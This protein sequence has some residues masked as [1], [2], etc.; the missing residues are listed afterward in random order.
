MGHLRPALHDL[1]RLP[2]V[3]YR[4]VISDVVEGKRIVV[5]QE[6]DGT[7]WDARLDAEELRHKHA[8]V[9]IYRYTNGET[10]RIWTTEPDDSPF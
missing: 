9:S 6:V 2:T 5:H 1:R 3:K 8:S 4:L 7:F 10:D